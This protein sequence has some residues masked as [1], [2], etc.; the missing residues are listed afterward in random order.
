MQVDDTTGLRVKGIWPI[1]SRTV[2]CCIAVVGSMKKISV[3][4]FTHYFVCS[5]WWIFLNERKPYYYIIIYY[6]YNIIG[7]YYNIVAFEI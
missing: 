2:G 4:L 5:S 6:N 1:S 7:Q 3:S